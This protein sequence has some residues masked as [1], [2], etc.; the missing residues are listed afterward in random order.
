[1]AESFM[2]G[3]TRLPYVGA[4]KDVRR[5][6]LRFAISALIG[7]VAGVVL[8]WLCA[9]AEA[10]DMDRAAPREII[11]PRALIAPRPQ[12]PR[13]IDS[14]IGRDQDRVRDAREAGEI[15]SF[16]EIRKQI[17]KR[18]GGHIIDVDLDQ[19]DSNDKRWI[20]RV[21]MLAD[22]GQ[23]LLVRADAATGEIVDVKGKN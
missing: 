16:G 11:E 21:R 3:S 22:N 19:D 17:T 4:M 6:P 7:A 20:Y 10:R 9:S 13:I 1:V 23:V 8:T 12:P 5:Q 2:I 18:Y 15:K 14:Y